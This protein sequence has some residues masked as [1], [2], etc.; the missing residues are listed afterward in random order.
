M[1]DGLEKANTLPSYVTSYRKKIIDDLTL[2]HMMYLED[3]QQIPYNIGTVLSDDI[4][5][6]FDRIT[7]ETQIVAMYRYDYLRDNYTELVVKIRHH[8]I[9]LFVTNDTYITL[10]HQCGAKEGSAFV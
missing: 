9:V 8:T 2:N 3:I 5:I 1:S 6:F 7:T 4:E 10:P